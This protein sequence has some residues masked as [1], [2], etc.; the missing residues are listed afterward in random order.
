MQKVFIFRDSVV[1]GNDK[2]DNAE[3]GAPTPETK[4][5]GVRQTNIHHQ[6]RLHSN[7]DTVLKTRPQKP[8]RRKSAREKSAEIL[9]R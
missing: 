1:W 6:F 4:T 2:V 7:P 3:F 5:I 8:I 9:S